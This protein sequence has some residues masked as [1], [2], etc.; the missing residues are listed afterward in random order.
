MSWKY[1]LSSHHAVHLESG[2][3]FVIDY[4]APTLKTSLDFALL[5]AAGSARTWTAAELETLKQELWLVMQEAFEQANLRSKLAALVK[6][7]LLGDYF[8]AADV[9]SKIAGKNVSQRSIQAWLLEPDKRS[10]RKCPAWAVE[11]L[12][13][14][15]AQPENQKR[16]RDLVNYYKTATAPT[17]EPPADPKAEPFA[18]PGRPALPPDAP[19]REQW[20]GASLA[21][22]P[23][24]LCEMEQR[25]EA[26]LNYFNRAI[27]AITAT[28]MEED[29]DLHD[30]RR[31]L[32][33]RLDELRDYERRLPGPAATDEAGDD[34]RFG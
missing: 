33:D 15:L 12:E 10:S 6:N 20:Q 19:R 34:R 21:A 5:P 32:R 18:E 28:L 31:S 2:E 8:Q 1:T 27:N 9:I 4:I 25:M 3:T 24:M 14:Y 16:L 23:D 29:R 26:Y 22:L 11:A 7:P 13:T 30:I 17:A